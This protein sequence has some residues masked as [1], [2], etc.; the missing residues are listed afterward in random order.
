MEIHPTAIV[1]P[2]AVI[3]A[4]T[5][6]GPYCVIGPKVVLGRGNRLHSH[7]V[8]EGRTTIGDNNEIFQFA[9]VG[10][11]PQDLKYKG[12]SSRLEIGNGNRIREYVTIQ[13]GTEGG[14]MLTKVGNDNLF[15][16][17]AHVGH[18]V[19]IGDRNVIANCAALAGHV[20]LGSH[21]IVGGLCGIHQFTRIGD[22][23][24]LGGGTMVSKDIPPYTIAHGDHARLV[25]INSIGLRRQGFDAG[26]IK[27]IRKAFRMVFLGAGPMAGR[28]AA[29]RSQFQQDPSVT[30]L[31]DFLS[32][33][34]RG[35]APVRK[36]E[37]QDDDGA[38]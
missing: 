14:G 5:A 27:N 35:I 24:M 22:Y 32:S 10:S 11:V 16:V 4:G 26:A 17:S 20:T 36:Q 23:A 18:D 31:L 37:L 21:V 1:A 8:V 13:I 33:S 30:V 2:E 15:M 9:S 28:I 34:E 29:A 25:G 6:I 7:V 19:I 38:D 3:G 12:E